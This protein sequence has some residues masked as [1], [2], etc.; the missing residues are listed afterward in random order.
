MPKRTY[1]DNER[2][3]TLAVLDSNGGNVA[4]TS[5]DS[6]VP[7]KT[8]SYWRD[9]GVHR[10]VEQLRVGKREEIANK[11][12]EK[13]IAMLGGVT[14]KKIGATSI[15]DLMTGVGIAVDKSLLLRGEAP[16]AEM[17]NQVNVFIATHLGSGE[18]PEF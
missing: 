14:R 10:D 4:K 16:G 12:E 8:I 15:K 9:G 11:I 7:I 18:L 1:S 17:S 13:T 6:G 3:T 5:R 2:A